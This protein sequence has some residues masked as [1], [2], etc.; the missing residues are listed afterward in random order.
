MRGFQALHIVCAVLIGNPLPVG[1][2]VTVNICILYRKCIAIAVILIHI[3]IIES[4]P[5]EGIVIDER[6]I[7]AGFK[8]S[9]KIV[10]RHEVKVIGTCSGSVRNYFEHPLHIITL[11]T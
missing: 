10:I 5:V 1:L 9:E 11:V 7:I 8:P 4:E 2:H 6:C 3:T